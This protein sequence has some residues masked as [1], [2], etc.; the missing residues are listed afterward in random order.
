ML[1]NDINLLF[2]FFVTGRF[3]IVR[4]GSSWRE[5]AAMAR[6]PAEVQAAKNWRQVMKQTFQYALIA[7]VCAFGSLVGVTAAQADA[8]R[9]AVVVAENQADYENNVA[10]LPTFAALLGKGKG[11]K[12]VY[13]GTDAAKF[14]ITTS[15]VW[16]DPADISSVTDTA[17]WK[18]TAAKLKAKPYA[19]EVFTIVP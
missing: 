18:A 11:I 17:D 8:L 16:S 6:D 19:G 15:S 7:G 1:Y 13:V 5:M 10:L 3:D 12:A 4:F 14:T 9:V 2:R